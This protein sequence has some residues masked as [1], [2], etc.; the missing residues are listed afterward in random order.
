MAGAGIRVG[1]G[2]EER[3]RVELVDDG[4]LAL[5]R[6]LILRVGHGDDL[7]GLIPDGLL[8]LI[9]EGDRPR[10]VGDD[11]VLFQGTVL[12]NHG[13]RVEDLPLGRAESDDLSLRL[14]GLAE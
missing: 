3:G 7:L 4:F 2:L 9:A 6:H 11:G 5:L 1:A 14:S 10:L 8:V 13:L 12:G